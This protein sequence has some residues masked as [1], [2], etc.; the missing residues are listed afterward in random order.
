M[1]LPNF[2][3][4]SPWVQCYLYPLKNSQGRLQH[5]VNIYFDLTELKKAE[6]RLSSQREEL[7]RYNRSHSL[8]QLAGSIAH[9]LN[10][11]LTGI[12]S[13]SQAGQL[14]L[15]KKRPDPEIGRA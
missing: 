5:V 10:Q 2:H 15:L 4:T 11:P 9:E 6:A 14:L 1:G 7:I 3:G 13:N 12:L 8:G